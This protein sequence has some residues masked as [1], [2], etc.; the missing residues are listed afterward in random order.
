MKGNFSRQCM[1]RLL[2]M[3]SLPM[4][5]R[6]MVRCQ[7]V[8]FRSWHDMVSIHVRGVQVGDVGLLSRGLVVILYND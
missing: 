5:R 6:S 8:E 2:L 3:G 4:H 1:Y 7:M